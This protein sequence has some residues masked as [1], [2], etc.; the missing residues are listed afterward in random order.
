MFPEAFH[1]VARKKL[2]EF[3]RS[4]HRRLLLDF[5]SDQASRTFVDGESASPA[6]AGNELLSVK[7]LLVTPHHIECCPGGFFPVKL[8]IRVAFPRWRMTCHEI[9][10]EWC[11]PTE[12]A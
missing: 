3:F 10:I 7:E 11:W 6:V 12:R 8:V 2:L 1:R 5:N 4:P 9:E